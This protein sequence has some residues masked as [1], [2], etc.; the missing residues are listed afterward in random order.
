MKK[1]VTIIMCLFCAVIIFFTFFG[2]TLFYKSKPQVTTTTSYTYV[3]VGEDSYKPIPKSCVFDDKYVYVVTSV[4]GFSAV[5]YTV[6]KREITG[7][8]LDDESY[9]VTDGL[10]NGETIVMET[11]RPLEDGD[12]VTVR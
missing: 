2:E 11:D 6:E 8:E 10:R 1:V 12:R 7:Y 3:M 4:Q 5:I 9:A